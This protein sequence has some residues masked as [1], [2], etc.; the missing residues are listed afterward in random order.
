MVEARL[1][2]A[3]AVLLLAVARDRDEDAI[4]AAFI[5]T[6]QLGDL[7]AV[8]PGEPKIQEDHLGPLASGHRD[9][10]RAVMGSLDLVTGGFE[11]CG[12]A[13]CGIHVVVND[14]YA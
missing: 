5:L 9:G 2:R 4:R 12:Q 10:G 7:E 8:H 1:T 6:E 13:S 3:A 11:Q 14:E